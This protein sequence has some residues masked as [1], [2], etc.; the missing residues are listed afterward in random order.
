MANLANIPGIRLDLWGPTVLKDGYYI[1]MGDKLELPKW[2][3]GEARINQFIGHL[4]EK[5]ILTRWLSLPK[6]RAA[7]LSKKFFII[8]KD[9]P[10]D[11]RMTLLTAGCWLIVLVAVASEARFRLS[12][13]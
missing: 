7:L 5:E 2:V 4:K 13:L 10:G 11:W 6:E 12:K 8:T 9:L 1:F 3:V